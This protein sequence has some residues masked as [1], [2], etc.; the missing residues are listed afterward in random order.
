MYSC[1]CGS[2]KCRNIA[3]DDAWQAWAITGPKGHPLSVHKSRRKTTHCT[4]GSFSGAA[5]C[6][7]WPAVLVLLL[8]W[9][10]MVCKWLGAG[11]SCTTNLLLCWV[12][13]KIEGALSCSARGASICTRVS[14]NKNDFT[15]FRYLLS[16]KITLFQTQMSLK[17]IV[18]P[19]VGVR[20]PE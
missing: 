11:Q 4:M 1:V 10:A 17:T 8:F 7:A 2:S 12:L 3:A 19:R 9:V 20:L 14:S 6:S 13:R 15:C 16:H 5:L 18:A